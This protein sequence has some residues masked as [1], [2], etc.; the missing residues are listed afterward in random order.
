MDVICCR[1]EAAFGVGEHDLIYAE[2]I[3]EYESEPL[4]VVVQDMI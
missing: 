1:S 2:N 4:R 3:E